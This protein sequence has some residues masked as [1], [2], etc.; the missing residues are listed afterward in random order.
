MNILD[1]SGNGLGLEGASALVPVL[2]M[3]ER[4]GGRLERLVLD[5]NGLG[6]S[7]AMALAQGLRRNSMLRGRGALGGVGRRGLSLA[8]NRLQDEGLESLAKA[9]PETCGRRLRR[10]P[11]R[12]EGGKDLFEVLFSW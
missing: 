7:G 2:E 8:R 5:E 11:E 4:D 9:I 3:R 12:E 1:L 6:P 10:R